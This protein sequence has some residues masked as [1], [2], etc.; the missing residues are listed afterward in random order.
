MSSPIV[1][2]LAKIGRFESSL[3]FVLASIFCFVL[4]IISIYS[5]SK[6]QFKAGFILLGFTLLIFTIAYYSNKLVQNSTTYAAISG[7]S[8]MY[9]IIV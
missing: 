9:K 1:E 8:D 6:K 7:T 3:K 5:F 2:D 4:L